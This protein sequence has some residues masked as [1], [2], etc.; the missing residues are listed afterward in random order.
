[1]D[2]GKTNDYCGTFFKFKI[3]NRVELHTQS[4]LDGVSHAG[5]VFVRKIHRSCNSPRCPVCCFSGWAK[6]V[7]GQEFA[8]RIEE[9]TKHYGQ[10]QHIIIPVPESDYYLAEFHNDPLRVKIKQLIFN[11]GVVGGCLIFHGFRYAD[12]QESIAK[13][14][15]FGWRWNPHYHC[16]G[17]ILGGYGKC[18]NCSSVLKVGRS[19]CF[20]C[21]G[22]E[23][24]TRH[25]LSKRQLHSQSQG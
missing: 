3:C 8:Q 1:M 14:V 22:F 16:I 2:M 24:R 7:S 9:A 18:R 17:F 11:R 6:V 5:Q 12:Y 21:D 23:G 4:N 19:K 10:P 13:G 15:L 20:T 25:L